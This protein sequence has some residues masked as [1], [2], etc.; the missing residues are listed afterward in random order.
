VVAFSVL[1]ERLPNW[2]IADDLGG[3]AFARSYL[4]RGHSHL[5]IRWS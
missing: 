1:L 5:W 2:T 3:E 4:L